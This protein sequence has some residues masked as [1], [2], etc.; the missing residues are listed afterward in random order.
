MIKSYQEAVYD[1][2]FLSLSGRERHL[3]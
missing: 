1:L 3:N 2:T